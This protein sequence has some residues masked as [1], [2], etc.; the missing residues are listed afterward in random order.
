[1][2][3][4]HH[5]KGDKDPFHR[6]SMTLCKSNTSKVF[7]QGITLCMKNELSEKGQWFLARAEVG[8]QKGRGNKV[9]LRG[10]V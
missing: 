10:C 4:K 9:L 8:K 2:V 6:P 7:G 5:L 3:E 1:M